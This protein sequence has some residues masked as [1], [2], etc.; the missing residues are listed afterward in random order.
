LIEGAALRLQ[1]ETV[2]VGA[3]AIRT[4]ESGTLFHGRVIERAMHA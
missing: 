3:K 2:M 4:Q 1:G